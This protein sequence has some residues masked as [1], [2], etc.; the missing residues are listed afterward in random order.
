MNSATQF[1]HGSYA[2]KSIPTTVAGVEQP[3]YFRRWSPAQYGYHRRMAAKR[4]RLSLG[5]AL[6]EIAREAPNVYNNIAP[7]ANAVRPLEDIQI[8]TQVVAG[9]YLPLITDHF[10]AETRDENDQP[11]HTPQ[12]TY[13]INPSADVCDNEVPAMDQCQSLDQNLLAHLQ[14]Q[15]MFKNRNAELL[16]SLKSRGMQYLKQYRN[17][18][19]WKTNQLALCVAKAYEPSEVEVLALSH[20][21]SPLVAAKAAHINDIL[22]GGTSDVTDFKHIK[23]ALATRLM[24]FFFKQKNL[25]GRL[26]PKT[27]V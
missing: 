24:D 21:R 23:P 27:Q 25:P 5:E 22:S 15:A 3:T 4:H 20:L 26:K 19:T 7:L 14:Q 1:L 17:P 6:T 12:V 18:E 10:Q 2:P 9:H 8:P 13:H 16:Q 11:V